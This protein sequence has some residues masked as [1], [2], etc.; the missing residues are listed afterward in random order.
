[1]ISLYGFGP[2]FGGVVADFT[3]GGAPGMILEV[4]FSWAEI[5]PEYKLHIVRN[6]CRANDR[7]NRDI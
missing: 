7:V 5:E 6:A 1:M 2:V 4:S 3:T